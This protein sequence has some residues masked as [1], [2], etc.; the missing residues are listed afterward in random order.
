MALTQGLFNPPAYASL[1]ALLCVSIRRA[2]SS[3]DE[4]LF[5]C[6]PAIREATATSRRP[7]CHSRVPSAPVQPGESRR[8]PH[9]VVPFSPPMAST[10]SQN[11][12]EQFY[13]VQLGETQL[14][15]LKRYQNLRLIGS[16]AQGIVW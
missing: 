16:G 10:S 11:V 9:P 13:T 8:P 15:I 14:V 3:R 7:T 2:E 1:P 5:S 4:S 6:S 12:P